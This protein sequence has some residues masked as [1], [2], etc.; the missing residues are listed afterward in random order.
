VYVR[1]LFVYD[2]CVFVCVCMW[3]VVCDCVFCVWCLGCARV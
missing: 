1:C 3:L 2:V